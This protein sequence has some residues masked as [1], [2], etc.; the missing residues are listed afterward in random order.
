MRKDKEKAIV[1]RKAGKTYNELG[2][3]LRIPRSTL[4]D[5]FRDQKWSNDIAGEHIKR[6][7]ENLSVK[8]KSLGKIRGE[9]LKEIYEEADREAVEDYEKLKF[10]P[11]FLAGVLTYWGEGEKTSKYRV[12]IANTDPKLIAIFSI[13]LRDICSIDRPRVWILLYP[14]L[15][16]KV[17]VDYWIK[18]SFLKKEFFAKSIVISGRSKRRKL[19]YGVCN[20]GVSSTYLKRKMMKWIELMGKDF[21]SEFYSNLNKQAG[22]V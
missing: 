5:W 1:L 9:R 21:V 22:I 15:N 19:G 3:L 6:L 11:L 16:E 13:F 10:H 2:R 20:I 12:I 14:D 8:M 18:N 7:R 17:C 4:S